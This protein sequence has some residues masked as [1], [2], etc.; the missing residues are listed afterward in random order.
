MN[1][2]NKYLTEKLLPLGLKIAGNKY[3]A[4][5]RDTFVMFMPFLIIG[6]IFMIIQ[7]FP[8]PGWQ[9][10]QTQVLGE[11]FNQFI[12]LPKRVTYDLMSLYIATGMGYQLSR[13]FKNTDRIISAFLSLAA[14]VL[15]TP[16]NTTITVNETLIEVPRVITVGGYYGTSGILVA[17]LTRST[18]C[19]RKSILFFNTWFRYFPVR[20]IDKLYFY[21]Y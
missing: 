15:I 11:W 17:L 12:I 14:F 3:L 2:I 16:I 18:S 4:S 21:E 6:S 10:F 7:D 13:H 20:I 8:A 9:E 5:I 19:C 1:K